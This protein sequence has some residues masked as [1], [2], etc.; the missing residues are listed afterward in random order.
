L[1]SWFNMNAFVFNSRLSESNSMVNAGFI[2]GTIVA[3]SDP[4]MP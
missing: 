3:V 2:S 1:R 4:R